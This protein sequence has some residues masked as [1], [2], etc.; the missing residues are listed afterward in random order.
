MASNF[1]LKN[2]RISKGKKDGKKKT[3]DPF[4]KKDWYDI[5]AP[6]VFSVRSVGKTLVSKTRGTKWQT[7]IEAHVDVKT[8][9]NYNLRLFCIAFTKR[10]IRQTMREIKINYIGRE[11]EKTTSS[12]FPLKNVYIRKVKILKAPKFDLRKLMEVHG[13]YSEDIGTKL[14][15]PVDESMAERETEV[16]GA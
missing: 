5:K 4:A 8:T 16:V 7:L 15:R 3:A 2:K 1:L 12:I 13:D 9:N 6:F 11:I 10:R 14:E